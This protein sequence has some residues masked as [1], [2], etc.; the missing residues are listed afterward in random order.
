M[1]IEPST[2]KRTI[3]RDV[4]PSK[5]LPAGERPLRIYLPPGY[6]ETASYSTVYCQDGEDFFNYGRIATF[7][8]Q[9]IVNQE[10]EP[11]IIIGIDVDKSV[12]TAEYAPDGDRHDA[13][14]AFVAEEL[15]PFIAG[16]YAVNH[17]PDRILLAGDSL[18]GTASMQLAL[19]Y[20]D[21]FAKVLSLSGAFY[22]AA[23][24]E[25][26][27]RAD[28]SYIEAYMLVGLQET[29]FET[30]RGIHNFVELNR[31]ALDLLEDRGADIHYLEKDG[32][33]KWG[34]WQQEVPDA[35]KWFFG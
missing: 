23:L 5:L 21:R 3:V 20:P 7:A 14:M 26:S 15:M 29:A 12:R 13:Y 8:H 28:L 35:L 2:A 17:A 30:D 32:E 24:Q 11:I 1:Q 10:I 19:N 31:S 16:K 9:L 27:T 33:H 18:G 34:F 22:E 25:L 4:A 6:S